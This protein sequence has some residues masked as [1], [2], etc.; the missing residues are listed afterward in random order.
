MKIMDG[1]TIHNEG[2]LAFDTSKMRIDP[3]ATGL[4]WDRYPELAMRKDLCS[5]DHFTFSNLKE[6][7]PSLAELNKTIIFVSYFC[8]P[9]SPFYSEAVMDHRMK[10]CL[11]AAGITEGRLRNMI[12]A[13]HWWVSQVMTAYLKLVHNHDFE[14]WLTFTMDYAEKMAYLRLPL[15]SL[16][17][18]MESAMNARDKIQKSAPALKDEIKKLEAKL[19]P[20]Q[21][22]VDSAVETIT[23]DGIGGWAEFFAMEKD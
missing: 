15:T 11:D 7:P 22:V 12:K 9:G 18:N 23:A 21:Y 6:E 2:I 13:R 5:I 10:V 17:D 20:N 16:T 1:A 4:L 19:F 8:D 14:M 3:Q